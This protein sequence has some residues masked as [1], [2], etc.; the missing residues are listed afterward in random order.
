MFEKFPQILS[1]VK[2]KGVPLSES[3]KSLQKNKY[4]FWGLLALMSTLQLLSY[5]FSSSPPDENSV[6][7]TQ[8]GPMRL[9]TF[10]PLGFQLIPIKI[11]NHEEL[12]SLIQDFAIVDLYAQGTGVAA[13]TSVRLIRAPNNPNVFAVLVEQDQ[14]QKILSQTEDFYVSLKNPKQQAKAKKIKR[15]LI[16]EDL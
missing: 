11:Y 2:L 14:A 10:V 15:T 9:D 13:A 8:D 12:S 1:E 6:T 3:L 5:G 4:F 7:Q 16:L